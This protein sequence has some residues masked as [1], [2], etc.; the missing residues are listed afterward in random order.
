MATKRILVTGGGGFIGRNVLPLLIER[1]YDVTALTLGTPPVEL[2]RSVRWQDADLLHGGEAVAVIRE[3]RP[4]IL[5]HLAWEARP[6]IYKTS[7]SNLDWISASINLFRAF[8]DSGGR[9]GVAAGTCAEYD[10]GN[11]SPLIENVSPTRP[12]TLYGAA[13]LA[14]SSLMHKFAHQRKAE[15]AWGRI[16]FVFGQFEPPGRLIPSV[17]GA[18]LNGDP[19]ETSSG[20]T[21]RDYVG[22]YEV[23]RAFVAIIESNIT[24]PVNVGSG[25]GVATATLLEKIVAVV[26]NA[27]MWKRGA[28]PNDSSEPKSVVADISRLLN[29]TS[30]EPISSLNDAIAN[31]VTWWR[32]LL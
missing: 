27:H 9:R 21:V 17:I 22:V 29:E 2:G 12:A 18:L 23:A 5:L 15:F 19:V 8:Y 24:G 10:W 32:S 16:F 7:E 30:Y 3:V 13:K 6:G 14:F 11:L 20:E 31:A 4:D 1:G 28:R 25:Q 26:G